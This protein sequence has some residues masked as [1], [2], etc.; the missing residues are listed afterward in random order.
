VRFFASIGTL[1]RSRSFRLL[2]LAFTAMALVNWI[3]YTWLPIFLFERF[4]LTLAGAGFSATFYIQAA[5]YTGAIAGGLITDRWVARTPRARVYSQASGMMVAAPF[6]VLLSIASSQPL[7]VAALVA[8]GLGRGLFDCNTM[9]NLLDTAPREL[10]ATGY[11]IFNMTGCIVGGAGAAVAGCM[12]SHLGLSAAFQ[13]AAVV[14]LAG[15]LTLL[16]L[17][18]PRAPECENAPTQ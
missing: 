2:T 9:P 11:G 15:G 16:R 17:P 6:L 1:L 10:S 3:V 14:L 12:K 5:S 8:F 18:K 13:L 4:H 7:L